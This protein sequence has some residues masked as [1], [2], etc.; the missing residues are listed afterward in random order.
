MSELG[1]YHLRVTDWLPQST[2]AFVDAIAVLLQ[3]MLIG[4][5]M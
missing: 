4:I 2:M 5:A 3:Q 1:F